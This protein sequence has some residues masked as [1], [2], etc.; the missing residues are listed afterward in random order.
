MIDVL[1]DGG[2][3]RVAYDILAVGEVARELFRDPAA[4]ESPKRITLAASLF[5]VAPEAI[6]DLV[7]LLG[8]TNAI[9]HGG[10]VDFEELLRRLRAVLRPGGRAILDLP[11]W[12]ADHDSVLGTIVY[13]RI[14]RSRPL[15]YSLF[16]ACVIPSPGELLVTTVEDMRIVADAAPHRAEQLS[17]LMNLIQ[18]PGRGIDA[19]HRREAMLAMIGKAV[20][21]G[22]LGFRRLRLEKV[23]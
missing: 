22:A 11:V 8:P 14:E 20:E 19:V 15:F 1:G 2:V 12:D 6:N 4:N 10:R 23:Q 18:A 5:D 16:A 9:A 3:S 13:E 17:R 7:L 21:V